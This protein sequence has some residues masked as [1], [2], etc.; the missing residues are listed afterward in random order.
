MLLRLVER[1]GWP[2]VERAIDDILTYTRRRLRNRIAELPDGEYRFERSLDDD[3][4]QGP[5]V[6]IVC[7]ARIRG[8]TSSSISRG[9]ARRRAAP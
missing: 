8:K 4:F 2:A 3:G 5:L 6:P 9:P 7:T 1:M